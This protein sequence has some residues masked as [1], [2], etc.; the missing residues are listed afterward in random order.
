MLPALSIWRQ[1]STFGTQLTVTCCFAFFP[2]PLWSM[3]QEVPACLI[4]VA[5]VFT[6]ILLE[7]FR[8]PLLPWL[9]VTPLTDLY[10]FNVVT[11]FP[12]IQPSIRGPKVHL[13]SWATTLWEEQRNCTAPSKAKLFFERDNRQK[14]CTASFISEDSHSFPLFRELILSLHYP[15]SAQ[16]NRRDLCSSTPIISLNWFAPLSFPWARVGFILG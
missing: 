1:L 16:E 14:L 12:S 2:D 10:V 11:L 8:H 6:G 7:K 13:S 3:C 9:T 15:Q 4:E 5:D